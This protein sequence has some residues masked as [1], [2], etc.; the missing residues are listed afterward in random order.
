MART[1]GTTTTCDAKGRRSTQAGARKLRERRRSDERRASVVCRVWRVEDRG[2]VSP[3]GSSK[4]R[5][6]NGEGGEDDR[7]THDD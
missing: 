3:D 2:I 6:S 7:S 1:N 5:V 4:R